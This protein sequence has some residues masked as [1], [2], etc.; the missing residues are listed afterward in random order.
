MASIIKRGKFF[1]ALVARRGYKRQSAT[2]DTKAEAES[3][4]KEIESQMV[5]RIYRDK[6]AAYKITLADALDRYE[7]DV[8][9][10]KKGAR[11]EKSRIGL[12]RQNPLAELTL[13][14]LR[15]MHFGDYR[16]AQR[17]AGRAENTIRLDLALISHLFTKARKEWGCEGLANPLD[18]V[19]KPEGSQKRNRR[20]SDAELRAIIAAD[21]SKNKVLSAVL[22]LALETAMR[23][24]E[25]VNQ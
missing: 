15:A 20:M 21:D 7:R 6:R 18:E 12:W 25:L 23:R 8:S 11:Q 10:R 3:W 2:F 5:L 1:R 24:S 16:D 22:Q 14:E 4:S 9:S 13:G 17:K 19:T